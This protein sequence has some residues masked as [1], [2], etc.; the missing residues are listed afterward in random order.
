M[1]KN[2]IKLKD[3]GVF[4]FISTSHAL[5]AE[6]VLKNASAEF[7]MIPTPR[8][9]S[10]SCGLSVKVTEDDLEPNW[11]ILRENRVEIESTYLVRTIEGKSEVERLFDE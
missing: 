11:D 1:E 2:L 8:Q 9:I 10:T 5:K 3:Y 4:T 7:L 6:R